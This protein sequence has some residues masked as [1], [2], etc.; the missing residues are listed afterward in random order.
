MLKNHEKMLNTISNQ[1]NANW[2]HRTLWIHENDHKIK[3]L[4]E[5]LLIARRG[6]VTTSTLE[7]D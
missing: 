1:K 6:S 5:L 4:Q 3:S 2:N 7:G